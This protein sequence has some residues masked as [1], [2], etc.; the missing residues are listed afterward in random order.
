MGAP[1]VQEGS[2]Q[3]QSSILAYG[4]MGHVK[5]VQLTA[6]SLS[7]PGGLVSRKPCLNESKGA[8]WGLQGKG[9]VLYGGW[10]TSGK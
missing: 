5:L 8:S 6:H 9:A 1:S 4:V 7:E 3:L 2:R 10:G